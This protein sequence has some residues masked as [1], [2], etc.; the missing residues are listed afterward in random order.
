VCVIAAFTGVAL[1]SWWNTS[2][3]DCTS[4]SGRL[5]HVAGVDLELKVVDEDVV[6]LLV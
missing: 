2:A 6:V 1:V 5:N 3:W 4:L